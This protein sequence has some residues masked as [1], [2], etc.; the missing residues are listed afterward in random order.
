MPSSL[1]NISKIINQK[2]RNAGLKNSAPGRWEAS[3]LNKL[4]PVC[5]GENHVDKTYKLGMVLHAYNPSRGRG[6]R[7]ESL[8]SPGLYSKTLPK[9]KTNKTTRKKWHVHIGGKR[10]EKCG[11]LNVKL[12]HTLKEFTC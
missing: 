3:V 7:T 12:F 4:H 1:S 2:V 6:G 5:P 11:D 9:R 8:K 10:G